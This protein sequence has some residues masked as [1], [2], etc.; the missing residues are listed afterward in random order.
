MSKSTISKAP[1]S[2]LTPSKAVKLAL[3][4]HAVVVV[5][6]DPRSFEVRDRRYGDLLATIRSVKGRRGK[7]Y[8]YKLSRHSDPAAMRVHKGFQSLGACVQ[9][10]L[11]KV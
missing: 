9:R 8:S 6:I 3:D 2:R 7:V 11:E 1:V 10:V 5:R 4:R